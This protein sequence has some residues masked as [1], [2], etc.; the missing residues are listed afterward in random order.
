MGM[1]AHYSS[2]IVQM[3]SHCPIQTPDYQILQTQIAADCPCALKS[4]TPDLELKRFSPCL[5]ETPSESIPVLKL[6]QH[7]YFIW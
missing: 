6:A 2:C 3:S 5:G 4:S 1:Q 7:I